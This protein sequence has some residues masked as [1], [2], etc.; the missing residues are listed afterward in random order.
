MQPTIINKV[1]NSSLNTLNLE[2]FL[3]QTEIL[4]FDITP[5][6]YMELILKEKEFRAALLTINWEAYTNKHVA[7]FCSADAIVPVWAYMLITTYITP[8]AKTVHLN[9]VNNVRTYLMLQNINAIDTA[10]F[11]A[12]RVVIK[13]CGETPIPNEAYIAIAHKLQPIAKSIM[14]GEPCSTVPIYKN[15]NAM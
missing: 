6:L 12:Q 13:G 7:I 3:P 11:Y 1:A 9:T 10:P 2:S 15:K 5:Y 4:G 14:Y 8:F